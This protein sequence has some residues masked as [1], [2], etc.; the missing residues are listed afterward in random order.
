MLANLII[1]VLAV[2]GVSDGI[3]NTKP[4]P[5]TK[6]GIEIPKPSSYNEKAGEDRGGWDRN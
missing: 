6:P 3:G 1:L 4:A 2:I 5:D